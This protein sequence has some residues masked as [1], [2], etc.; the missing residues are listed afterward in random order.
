M[1]L[2]LDIGNTCIK[3]LGETA[4]G[5][6]VSGSF[7]YHERSLASGLED[8]LGGLA[9]TSIVAANVG[10]NGV[11]EQVAAWAANKW[12]IR[13]VYLETRANAC[14]VINAYPVPADLGVD[15]WAALVSAHHY[16]PGAVCIIDCGSAVTVDVLAEDGM[17]LGGLIMP[18]LRLQRQSLVKGTA[19]LSPVNDDRKSDPGSGVFASDTQAAI[20]EGT[21]L[22]TAGAIDKAI[23]R[24]AAKQDSHISALL[25]GGDAL[26]IMPLL[27]HEVIHEPELVLKG[28]A[29]L[30]EETECDT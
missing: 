10:G 20:L 15:R 7:D 3:W 18:G 12:G 11:G 17:H 25:T 28:V 9:P 5:E 2:L 29:L 14:G 16:Y 24:V 6:P 8:A 4:G 27:G 30:A 1:R 22:M 21:H 26:A 19:Q 23:D 13:T